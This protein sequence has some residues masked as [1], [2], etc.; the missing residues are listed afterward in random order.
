MTFFQEEDFFMAS[1]VNG[2]V[3]ASSFSTFLYY[4][5]IDINLYGADA[6]DA[7]DDAMDYILKDT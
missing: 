3:S 6:D 1:L 4:N 2:D 5:I 7:P